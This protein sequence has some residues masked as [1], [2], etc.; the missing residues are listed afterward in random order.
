MAWGTTILT[1]FPEMFPG[2]LGCSIAGRALKSG[3]WNLET[4]NIR[5]FALDKHQSVDDKPFGGGSGMVMRPDIL[6]Q[7]IDYTRITHPN[8]P[9]IYMSPRGRLLTQ[10]KVREFA[11][12]DHITILC[13]RFEGIDERVITYYNIEEFSI[14]DYILSGGEIAAFAL[15]DACI[16]VLPGV[17]EKEIVTQEESFGQGVYHNLLEYPH[18]TR[19]ANWKGLM[20][21]EMLLSGHHEKISNWRLEQALDITERRRADLWQKYI[22]SANKRT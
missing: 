19:P 15:L 10:P 18:Y 20:V 9:I 11:N 13:G 1:L 2:P 22:V 4:H 6:G 17:L 16:R 12:L 21:P 14:G 7:A 8:S 3:I 5:D